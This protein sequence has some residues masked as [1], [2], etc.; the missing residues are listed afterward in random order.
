MPRHS[1][2]RP[3]GPIARNPVIGS[4]RYWIRAR[5]YAAPR[6]D[7]FHGIDRLV[8]TKR[9]KET[10]YEAKT[11]TLA[12]RRYI[13]CR[14]HQEAEK[15]AA[16]RAAIVAA[17]TLRPL[18]P[19]RGSDPRNTATAACQS[20]SVIVVDMLTLRISRQSM[21]HVESQRG[22]FKSCT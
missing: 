17:L 19:R 2:S 14:N 7:K 6:N 22:T 3:E 10:A 1:G 8:K 18:A 5:R 20:S 21:N 13:V 16:D 11:V 15:D 12:G 4:R 9:G